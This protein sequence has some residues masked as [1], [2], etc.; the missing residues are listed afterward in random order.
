MTSPRAPIV[1]I[2]GFE[3]LGRHRVNS[4]WEAVRIASQRLGPKVLAARLPVHRATAAAA[5]TALLE[6]HHPDACLL[7]GLARGR[8]LRI[9]QVARRPKVLGGVEMP[10]TLRGT[11]PVRET[12]LALAGSKLPYRV[13]LNA[14]RYVCDSTYWALLRFR[15][16]RGWPAWAGFLHVPPLSARFTAERLAR[17]MERIVRRRLALMAPAGEGT[18]R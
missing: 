2:T 16:G 18:G 7:T 10:P 15:Q 11:W 8:A 14:G 1:L 17:G 5:L 3:P 9:E 6:R 13:S 4:S 12:G